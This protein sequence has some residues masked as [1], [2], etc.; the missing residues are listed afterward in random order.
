MPHTEDALPAVI[1]ESAG[2]HLTREVPVVL[3]SATAGE[4]RS[5]LVGRT[6]ACASTI[7]VCRDGLLAGLLAVEKLLAA[8]EGA[9][10][11]DL[12]DMDPP[13]VAP[14]TDQELAAWKAVQ[15][16]EST[17]AVVDGSGR[18]L[19]FIPPQRLLYVLLQEHQEDMSRLSG[20]LRGALSARTALEE[21][22]VRR[23]LHRLPWLVVGLAG[24]VLAADLMASFETDIRKNVLLAFFIPGVVY[25]ADA[26]G[27]QTETLVVRGLSV[28]IPIGRVVL[29]EAAAG[30]LIGLGLAALSLPVSIWRW[31]Q[32][33]V[34]AVLALS[35]LAACSAA[36]I[37][38]MGLPWLFHR[39][40][41]DPAFGSGP[42]GTVIQDFLSIAIYLG[43][44]R[45][46]L[47]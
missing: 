11:E 38:A 4:A 2:E 32:P 36:T 18:F 3:P 30:L 16:G 31:G 14:E 8:P 42:L 10:I 13:V 35:L 29:Q 47:P 12:M 22:V 39:L 46:L 24:A 40:H 9:R 21:S 27:T 43:T 34:S 19:G 25:L 26:V 33:A 17:L 28:G 6:F 15:H 23:F 45:L 44:A 20:L 7:A 37:V 5:I 41:R 1:F